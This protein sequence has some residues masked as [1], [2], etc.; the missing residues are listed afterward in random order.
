MK[1]TFILI[2]SAA[3]PRQAQAKYLQFPV[4][5]ELWLCLIQK[6]EH[7]QKGRNSKDQVSQTLVFYIDEIHKSTFKQNDKV[8]SNNNVRLLCAGAFA[9]LLD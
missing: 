2:M 6:T 7:G 9:I 4:V 3:C 5:S 1:T 8:H